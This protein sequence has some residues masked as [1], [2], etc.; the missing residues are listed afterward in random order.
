M[1]TYNNSP[2][3]VKLFCTLFVHNYEVSKQVTSHVQEYTCKCCKRQ[4]NTDS[5]GDL[6]ELT[7]QFQEINTILEVMYVR[8]M[9][10]SQEKMF[11]SSVY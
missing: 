10:R 11:T 5:N 8:R 1:K 7:P 2:A 3:P 6:T 4:L 9:E